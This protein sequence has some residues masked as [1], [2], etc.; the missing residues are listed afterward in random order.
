MTDRAPSKIYEESR[1]I[2]TN[3]IDFKNELKASAIFNIMQ[4]AASFHAEQMGLGFD[5]L[6]KHDMAWVLSWAKIQ[7]LQSSRFGE[8]I[9][10][11]TWPKCKHRLF[12]MRDF[13]LA[14]ANNEVVVRGTTAWLLMN[15]ETKKI[16]DLA[17]LP[18]DISYFHEEHALEEYP[19]K[20]DIEDTKQLRYTKKFRYT[21]IDVNSHVNNTKYVELMLDCFPLERYAS[22]SI[23]EVTIRF[24]SES[25]AGDELDIFL[26]P[27]PVDKQIFTVE[28]F[29][30]MR[31]QTAFR[32][33][34]RWE[35]K[36]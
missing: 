11:R 23:K 19:G 4:E 2:K 12:S 21:D 28:G 22:H 6:K 25:F 3:D 32:A 8:Q 35:P 27:D 10:I 24:H 14:N 17:S 36:N 34:V 18:I 16:C 30:R 13:T 1:Y 20:F 15:I 29:N 31:A 33:I 5:S 7:C 9:K 26:S